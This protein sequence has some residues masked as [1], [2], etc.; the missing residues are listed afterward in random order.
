[1]EIGQYINVLNK[2]QY[3]NPNLLKRKTVQNVARKK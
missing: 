1:M 3:G 2:T